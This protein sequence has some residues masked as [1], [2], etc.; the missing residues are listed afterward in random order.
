MLK[1]S[2]LHGFR[3]YSSKRDSP[4]LVVYQLSVAIYNP[5]MAY[6]GPRKV[7][8]RIPVDSLDTVSDVVSRRGL[9]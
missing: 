6:H 1:Q 4:A 8:D 3:E 9:G 2:L 7:T 5:V